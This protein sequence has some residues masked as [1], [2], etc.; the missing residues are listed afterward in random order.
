MFNF[1]KDVISDLNN[2][3]SLNS[4]INPLSNIFYQSG[5]YK[6]PFCFDESTEILCLNEKLEEEYIQINKLKK[7]SLVKSFKHGYRK[8]EIIY[9][10]SFVNDIN[11]FRSCMFLLP[12]NENMTK[13]LIIT[14]GH[15]ILVD[16]VS[17]K[18]NFRNLEYFGGS[19]FEIDGKQLLLASASEKF[20]PL[21][22]S[23][24]Y[25]YYHF[26]LENDDDNNARYGIW[27]NGILTETP[28]KNNFLNEITFHEDNLLNKNEIK[29]KITSK[30]ININFEKCKV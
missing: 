1:K 24:I 22:N 23:N 21:E 11:D 9:K 17:E 14:G 26:I 16:Y 18:E 28:S 19:K 10:G 8:I 29:E 13:D 12:K 7:G 3:S 27:A 5:S 25:T 15:S 30:E 6:V 2:S 20:I 4:M